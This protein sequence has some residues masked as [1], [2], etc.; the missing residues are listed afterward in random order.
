MGSEMVTGLQI[1]RK[2]V[3]VSTLLVGDIGITGLL[4]MIT[5]HL[6]LLQ[7]HSIET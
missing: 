2:L 6:K 1:T 4:L 7:K 3:S 5:V